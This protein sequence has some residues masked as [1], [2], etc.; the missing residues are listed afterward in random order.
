MDAE[1]WG[2]DDLAEIDPTEVGTTTERTV[3]AD[4]GFLGPYAAST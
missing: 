2:P 3:R 1:F 4:P